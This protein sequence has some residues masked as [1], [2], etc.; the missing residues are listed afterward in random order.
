MYL[1]HVCVTS[2]FPDSSEIESQGMLL[3]VFGALSQGGAKKCF[4]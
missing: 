2:A 1:L 4:V 3:N